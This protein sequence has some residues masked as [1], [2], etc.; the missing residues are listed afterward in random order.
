MGSPNRNLRTESNADF[1]RAVQLTARFPGQETKAL[2][3]ARRV[4]AS[5]GCQ[6]FLRSVQK[7]A[8]EG[9]TQTDGTWAS[10]VASGFQVAAPWVQLVSRR[11]IFGQLAYRRIP[12]STRTIVSSDAVNASFVDEGSAIRVAAASLTDTTTMLRARL[13][14]IVIVTEEHLET[15]SDSAAAQLNDV[16]AVAVAR[17]LDG[18]LLDPESAAS[19]TIPGSLTSGIS[20]SGLL[21]DSAT[22]ALSDLE[23]LR[24]G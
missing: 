12:F 5:L 21:T 9:A 2:D 19:G 10:E 23:D 20:A 7:A 22:G 4:G 13:G 24:S 17:G 8:I 11:T 6:T 18:A 3:Y 15:W 16:L 1:L 14:V